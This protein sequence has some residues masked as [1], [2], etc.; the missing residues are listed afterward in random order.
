MIIGS[1]FNDKYKI[2]SLI[3]IN[4]YIKVYLAR[5]ERLQKDMVIKEF[6][7]T[8]PYYEVYHRMLCW[9]ID[10]LKRLHHDGIP[11]LYDV[12]EKDFSIIIIMD[13]I[14][15]K[16]LDRIIQETAPFS[17]EYT[18]TISKKL[19]DILHYIHAHNLIYNDLK[20]ANI[21]ITNN[22][23]I[24]LVN[25]GACIDIFKQEVKNSFM[26]EPFP[27]ETLDISY[28]L[29]KK[30]NTHIDFCADIYSFGATLYYMLTGS[31]PPKNK[32]PYSVK[33]IDK[34]FSNALDFI[35]FKCTL[36]DPKYRYQNFKQLRNQFENI[37]SF[38]K[39]LK[40]TYFFQRKF[41]TSTRMKIDNTQENDNI[42]SS[43]TCCVED[44][45]YR[46]PPPAS[47]TDKQD[48]Y[49]FLSYCSQDSDLADI[50]YNK[51][52]AYNFIHIS[53]YTINVPYKKSF[54]EFM[55]TLKEHDKVIMII[56]DQ[57][58]KS[59]A[60]MY[61]VG[62]LISCNNFQRKILFIICNNKDKK[63]YKIQPTKN[64]EAKIYDPHERNQYIIYW[65]NQYALLQKDLN[66]IKDECA[67]IETLEIMRNIKK[68][69]SNDIGLFMKY[70]ADAKG[71]SFD[72]LYQHNFKEF[73]GELKID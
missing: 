29:K 39:V 46:L 3:G 14:Q 49:I 37:K 11:Q 38:E 70:L 15:G 58:L 32:N 21:L 55:N 25:F 12:I 10:I 20:P 36:A 54:I 59:N 61:E 9:E 42:P 67:K 64:I 2:I 57:Y 43:F 65:E 1:I 45:I 17:E 47:I 28:T 7:K 6:Q 41:E 22:N 26:I 62:Q 44:N 35:I 27:N 50:I 18:I 68:I 30:L 5:D 63:Y 13:Y 56:T 71:I 34:N 48:I 53:Q 16:T 24:M 73:F 51:F 52:C 60:C 31:T 69:I 19:I 33:K 4:K 40:F 8:N 66:V 23:K 72:E